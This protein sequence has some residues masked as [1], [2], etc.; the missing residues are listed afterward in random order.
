MKR[1]ALLKVELLTGDFLSVE[2]YPEVNVAWA[3]VEF[4]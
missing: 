4:R 1:C 3:T 2:E